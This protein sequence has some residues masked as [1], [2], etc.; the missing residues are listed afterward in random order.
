MANK[1]EELLK[2]N[3][4][5]GTIKKSGLNDLEENIKNSKPD[6]VITSFVPKKDYGVPVLLGLPY[7][8]GMGKQDLDKK[9]LEM[10]K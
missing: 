1:V 10:L 3:N 2:K 5:S 4:L 8:T 7:I 6:L 9:I